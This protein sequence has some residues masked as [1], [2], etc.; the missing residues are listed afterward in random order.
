MTT[1]HAASITRPRGIAPATATRSSTLMEK[2]LFRASV[3]AL[4]AGKTMPTATEM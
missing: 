2:R 3:H 4:R 1:T